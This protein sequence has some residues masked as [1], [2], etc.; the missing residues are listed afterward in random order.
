[1]LKYLP[2]TDFDGNSKIIQTRNRSFVDSFDTNTSNFSISTLHIL[3]G[4][5]A[6]VFTLFTAFLCFCFIWQQNQFQS[7]LTKIKTVVSTCIVWLG[8]NGTFSTKRLYRAFEKY[9][10]VIKWN[11]W[12]SWKCSVLGTHT[13]NHNNKWLF[14]LVFVR[15][16]LNTKD[17]TTV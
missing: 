16:S 12:E 17:I 8:F 11:Y 2:K 6:L 3:L 10:A 13:T 5:E 14:N 7:E 1:V 9:V 15:K 4:T